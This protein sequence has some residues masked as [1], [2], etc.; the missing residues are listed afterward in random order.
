M[1]SLVLTGCRKQGMRLLGLGTDS[2]QAKFAIALAPVAD[3]RLRA[4][5]A[6]VAG[7][8]G[9]NR[10]TEPPQQSPH[11]KRGG[12]PGA[13]EMLHFRAYKVSTEDMSGREAIGTLPISLTARAHERP[14]PGA[15]HE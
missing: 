11:V 8:A 9:D 4:S 10:Q 2:S 12:V 7:S 13:L 3:G 14:T 15:P 5:A 1:A 6:K